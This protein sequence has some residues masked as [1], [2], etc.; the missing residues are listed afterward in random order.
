MQIRFLHVANDEKFFDRVYNRFVNDSR[1]SNSAF[2]MVKTSNENPRWI[3]SDEVELIDSIVKAKQRLNRD[4]YDVI[5]FHSMT[6]MNWHLL[7]FVPKDKI[8]IWWLYGFDIYDGVNG[9]KPIIPLENYKA[10]TKR[11]VID[12]LSNKKT[13]LRKV[14]D[15]F[16][17]FRFKMDFH[18]GLRRIGYFQPIYSSEMSLMK[19]YPQFNAKEFYYNNS[20]DF[21]LDKV[22]NKKRRG[23]IIIGNSS[24]A[25]NNHIDIWKVLS[26]CNIKNDI[27]IPVSYGDMKYK[28]IIK[29]QIVCDN[30]VFL[31]DFMPIDE[32]Y[33]IL[34]GCSFLI[35]GVVRQQ[36]SENIYYCLSRGLK[37]FFY[38]DS[39]AYSHFKN[40]GYIVFAIEDIDTTSFDE[41]LTD[42]EIEYNQNKVREE[43]LRCDDIYNR[44][45]NELLSL[46]E[47]SFSTR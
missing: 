36:A 17:R 30:V 14:K 42:E 31:E 23:G 18:D 26:A 29:S 45:I 38:K 12:Y 2:L 1:I 3:H 7:R 8:V 39:I 13:I 37:V 21:K 19:K 5:Y 20:L 32:Y 16:I 33:N 22:T 34:N 6:V 10:F 47:A 11:I 27:I 44:T 25:T 9:A 35:S 41:P 40:N 4:D 28:S 46:K 43:A 15:A 24:S